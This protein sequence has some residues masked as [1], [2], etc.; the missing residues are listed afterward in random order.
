M[1]RYS[2]MGGK[3]GGLSP[4]G[5]GATNVRSMP[6]QSSGGAG[7]GHKGT[8]GNGHVEPK[9]RGTMGSGMSSPSAKGVQ[10]K[11]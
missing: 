9:A 7:Y 10:G 8:M 5:D 4:K 1:K 2:S 11:S 6:K 3:G